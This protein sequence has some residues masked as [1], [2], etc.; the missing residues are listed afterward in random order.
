MRFHY[1]VL[2][3]TLRGAARNTTTDPAW[4]RSCVGGLWEEMGRLQFD[5]L[6]SQGLRPEHYLL[7]IGC[8]CL[9]GG[10]H[11]IRYLQ[12]GHYFGVD[13]NEELLKAGMQELKHYNLIHKWPMLVQTDDFEL[14]RL[15]QN[16]EFAIAQSV[17]THLSVNSIIRC[18]MNIEKVLL[19]GGRFYATFFENLRGKFDLNPIFH[20]QIDGPEFPT[21]FDQDPYH[22]DFRT[23][24][25]ICE[26]T[27]LRV[28][29]L[30]PWNHPRDQRMVVFIK[31]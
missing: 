24:E 30:G 22:Y 28:E 21:Y 6:I 2:V 25:S 13:K 14:E 12:L 26:G 19:S 7:D 10:V 1:K 17:F 23:F 15:K 29:Y 9:R 11:F 20:S 5:F 31:K 27:S 3:K 18:L 16:F 4:H 8:G